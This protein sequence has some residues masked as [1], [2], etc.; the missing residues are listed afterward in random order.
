MLIFQVFTVLM[1]IALNMEVGNPRK[2][3]GISLVRAVAHILVAAH[4]SSSSLQLELL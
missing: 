4:F 3:A 1:G 2:L